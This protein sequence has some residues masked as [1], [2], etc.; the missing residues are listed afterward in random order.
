[1]VL[2]IEA[3]GVTVASR[4]LGHL[5]AMVQTAKVKDWRRRP[6]GGS[7]LEPIKILTQELAYVPS[8][9]SKA[10]TLQQSDEDTNQH[11]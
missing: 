10:K 11:H 4:P 9:N 3:I 2:E 1:V 8:S 5:L 7:E 6:E